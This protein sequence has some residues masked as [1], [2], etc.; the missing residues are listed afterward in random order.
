M[1]EVDISIVT[2]RPDLALLAQ[3]LQ[4]LSEPAG[5]PART[6]FVQDNS[7]DPQVAVGLV[8]MRELQPGGAFARVDVKYSGAHLG[9]GKGHNATVARGSAPFVLLL[10]QD[11]VLE[12][13]VLGKLLDAAAGAPDDVAV[14][15]LRQIP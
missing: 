12:P 5:A 1:R 3:L 10:N 6:L 11:C 4:S 8:A 13:G 2:Y 14:W 15:E 9:F 7:P